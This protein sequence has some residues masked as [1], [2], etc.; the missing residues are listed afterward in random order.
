M[1]NGVQL[2]IKMSLLLEIYRV[3]YI[4]FLYVLSCIYFVTSCVL[5]CYKSHSSYSFELWSR[6][7][8]GIAQSV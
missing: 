2:V 8:V 3:Y 4:Q 6:Q 7:G 5:S 1:L